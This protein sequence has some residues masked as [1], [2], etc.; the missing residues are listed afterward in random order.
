MRLTWGLR[1]FGAQPGEVCGEVSQELRGFQDLQADY[2]ITPV[3][4]L[5]DG[6]KNIIHV[7]LRVDAAWYGEPQQVPAGRF[8]HAGVR[9]ESKH[10]GAN[11]DRAN[12]RLEIQ[13]HGQGLPGI[14]Q[15]RNV[16]EESACIDVNGVTAG[17]RHHGD[18]RLAQVIHNVLSR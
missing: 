1:L 15:W 11:F 12:T 4:D 17:R 5:A 8:F 13:L 7:A 10:D 3:P 6:L 2:V 16:R 14:L 9:I 18:P